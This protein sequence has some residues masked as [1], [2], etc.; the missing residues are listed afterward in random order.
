MRYQHSEAVDRATYRDDGLAGNMQLRVHSESHKEV[1]GTLRA[2]RDWNRLVNPVKN[3]RGGLGDRF[4]FMS[5]TVPECLPERLE[6][7]AYANEYAFLYD[8]MLQ[9]VCHFPIARCIPDI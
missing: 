4:S 7:L 6:L 9:L 5:A 3:Y 1:T 2:Q 8:G